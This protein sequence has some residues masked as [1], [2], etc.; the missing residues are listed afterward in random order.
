MKK[1]IHIAIICC[2]WFAVCGHAQQIFY[3]KFSK[4]QTD[5]YSI[6][7]GEFNN[8]FYVAVSSTDSSSGGYYSM[9]Y[10]LNSSGI[11][12]D[13]VFLDSCYTVKIIP[14][15]NS[16]NVFS[17]KYI[18]PGIAELINM[19]KYDENLNKQYDTVFTQ[20]NYHYGLYDV[21]LS[22]SNTFLLF[23]SRFNYTNGT[24]DSSVIS[25]LTDQ[26]QISFS[27]NY[28]TLSIDPFFSRPSI[29]EISSKNLILLNGLYQ[30]GHFFY[31]IRRDNLQFLSYDTLQDSQSPFH[32]YDARVLFD[33]ILI[34]QGEYWP[35]EY[36]F[37]FYYSDTSLN[38][39]QNK[40]FSS[41]LTLDERIGFKAIDTTSSDEIYIGGTQNKHGFGGGVFEMQDRWLTVFKT[42]TSGQVF[43]YRNLG[44]D[45]DYFLFHLKTTSD[46]GV[47]LVGTIWDWHNSMAAQRD[48]VVYKLDSMGNVSF[49]SQISPRNFG[50]DVFPNPASEQ[51]IFRINESKGPIELIVYNSYGNL[52]YSAAGNGTELRANV[53]SFRPGVYFYRV[54]TDTGVRSGSFVKQ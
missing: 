45:G 6:A 40:I 47:L 36:K 37:G 46:G 20:I 3:T 49:V 48:V 42:D 24:D 39:I 12:T 53:S 54:K 28:S 21:T 22:A 15:N 34:I 32:C 9:M 1:N 8:N 16:L 27:N 17:R 35:S 4:P 7:S 51:I 14:S 30:S 25:E 13:S 11:I 29:T 41:S 2:A 33:S 31:K 26:F 18:F 52:V 5:D 19:R 10:K 23:Y 43:W 38:L 50:L 44:G